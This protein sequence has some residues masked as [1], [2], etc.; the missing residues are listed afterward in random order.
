MDKQSIIKILESNIPYPSCI[1]K[2]LKLKATFEK[3]ADDILES[4]KK[5]TILVA[6]N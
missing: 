5:E 1:Y 3:I 6:D 2:K 4:E